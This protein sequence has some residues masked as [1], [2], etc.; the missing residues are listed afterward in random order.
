M[1]EL[2]YNFYQTGKYIL[3]IQSN[4]CMTPYLWAPGNLQKI[5]TQISSKEPT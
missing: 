2:L 5:G 4:K 3:L 1:Y